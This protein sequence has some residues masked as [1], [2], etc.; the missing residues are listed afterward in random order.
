M[1]NRVVEVLLLGD[2]KRFT[3][4]GV[5]A[6]RDEHVPQRLDGAAKVLMQRAQRVPA[7][8]HRLLERLLR[9]LSLAELKPHEAEIVVAD[10]DECMLASHGD[11]VQL[12]CAQKPRQ[13]LLG[14]ALL[15]QHQSH[16]V[17][18]IRE[19]GR[20]VRTPLRPL[21]FRLR[22]IVLRLSARLFLVDRLD[23][24]LIIDFRLLEREHGSAQ[25]ATLLVQ[26]AER[27]VPLRQH[28]WID[29]RLVGL[30]LQL[31]REQ[32]ACLIHAAQKPE[33]VDE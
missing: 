27:C 30:Q 32:R 1:P 17:E 25:V 13:R 24:E 19:L 26:P 22:Q 11:L 8:V 31:A 20:E 23:G 3:L 16:R 4:L 28:H 6:L 33:H 18:R 15:L 7:D 5:E 29:V 10:A 14:H 9:G 12:N 21:L 2:P